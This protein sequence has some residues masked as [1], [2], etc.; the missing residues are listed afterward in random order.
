M[1][2]KKAKGKRVIVLEYKLLSTNDRLI[3]NKD[4]LNK[5]IARRVIRIRL[6]IRI[7]IKI[8]E[9]IGNRQDLKR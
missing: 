9:A 1:F 8:Q 4:S 6:R 3:E 5:K 2:G 7:R